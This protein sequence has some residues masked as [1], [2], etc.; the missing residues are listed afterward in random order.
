LNGGNLVWK[1]IATE[2]TGTAT[3]QEANGKRTPRLIPDDGTSTLELTPTTE[4]AA[5]PADFRT[6]LPGHWAGSGG[7]YEL[8]ISSD[9]NWEYTSTVRGSWYARGTAR[10]EGPATIVLEGWFKGG[11]AGFERLTMVLHRRGESLAGEFR[12][13]QTWFVTFLRSSHPATK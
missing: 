10:I 12:L 3:E 8:T 9:L 2:R 7:G 1:A 6:W 11:R 4:V 5:V 13:S